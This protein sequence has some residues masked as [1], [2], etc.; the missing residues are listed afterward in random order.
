M[1]QTTQEIKTP[2]QD[3]TLLYVAGAIVVLIIARLLL[4]IKSPLSTF[5]YD[6]GFYLHAAKHPVAF[7]LDA[8]LTVLWGGYN[9]PVFSLAHALHI[10][11]D[12]ALNELYFFFIILMGWSL[13]YFG[14]QFSKNF[15][16]LGVLI[17]AFSIPQIEAYT[18]FLWKNIAALP[19]FILG[20]AFLLQKRWTAFI[21]S[22]AAI[23]LLHR[24]TGIVY[25]LTISLYFCWQLI[26]SKKYNHL[27]LLL[28]A[29]CLLL[30][31]GYYLFNLKSVI[32]NLLHHGN[33][34]V[35]TG[36]FLEE[37]NLFYIFWPLLALGISGLILYIK[38][39]E[40]SLLNIF[41]AVCAIW[42]IF[43]LPFYRRILLYIDLALIFYAAYF[44]SSI[45]YT[46]KLKIAL[47]VILI[48]LGYRAINHTLTT[49]PLITPG[50][51]QE[52]RNFKNPG[53]FILAVSA[54]DASW[55][56][57]YTENARLGAPGLFEDPHT[58]ED[59]QEFWQ[60]RNQISF[61]SKYPRPLYFYQ[62]TYRLE[63]PITKC[64]RQV[65]PNFFQYD[66]TCESY[67]E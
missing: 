60:G 59:W 48:F 25:L 35:R 31:A 58:Y 57:G 45:N 2:K 37:Q 42:F 38:N 63:G 44:L 4:L 40:S 66:F 65:S 67:S 50:Q 19:F 8:L 30:T 7:S 5:G 39:K 56:I 55:L 32:F 24:T 10:P 47:V 21:A 46:K 3:Y 17:Y 49:L 62:R 27:I 28:I 29:Y 9:N 14:R 20:F 41:F 54:N 12:I 6:Y 36:L 16:I 1:Q 15:G 51:V 53:S 43:K 11:P 22:S 52:I 34:Y 23:L 61:I 18:M 26:K 64:F 13:Y 33:F